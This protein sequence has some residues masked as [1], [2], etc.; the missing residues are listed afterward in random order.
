MKTSR[1]NNLENSD[2][3]WL[4][5]LVS[6][7]CYYKSTPTSPSI[8]SEKKR[9]TKDDKR[10]D[11]LIV[12]TAVYQKVQVRQWWYLTVKKAKPIIII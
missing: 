2:H 1:R 8:V 9:N 7:M 10:C 3:Y 5:M 11:T 6:H 4:Q 12:F